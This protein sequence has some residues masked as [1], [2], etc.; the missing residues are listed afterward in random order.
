MSSVVLDLRREARARAIR[1]DCPGELGPAARATW[2]A[3]MVNEH[4][5]AEVF[6]SLASQLADAGFGVDDVGD[7]GACR[8]FA[9]E[10]RE[11]GVL[12]GA[13]VESLGGEA[14]AIVPPQTG[15]PFP[16]PREPSRGGSPEPPLGVLHERDRRRR[17]HR[18]RVAR[19]A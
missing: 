2:L 11:H 1:I 10:E 8:R 18:G 7:V 4:E 9:R 17:A 3:R 16:R 12:C 6:E 13:V 15:G 5:S 14:R 19:D